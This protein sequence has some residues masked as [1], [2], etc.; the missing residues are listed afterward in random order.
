[1]QAN[2]HE[3]HRTILEQ[4]SGKT[5]LLEQ[6]REYPWGQ[7]SLRSAL[8]KWRRRTCQ[9]ILSANTLA[10]CATCGTT[11]FARLLCTLLDKKRSVR[12]TALSEDCGHLSK[13]QNHFVPS[14]T[15]TR[16]NQFLRAFPSRAKQG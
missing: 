1:M 11:T 16:I 9:D 6:R 14:G 8:W 5:I 10:G 15:L 3:R 7:I 4:E 12:R 2:Q 13:G